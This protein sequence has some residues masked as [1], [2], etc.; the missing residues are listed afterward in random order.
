MIV[1]CHTHIFESGRG[2]PF[3][4]PGGA[5]D[6]V[7]EMDAHLVDASIVLPTP[8]SATNEFVQ[9][10]CSR[11]PGRLI[12]F[13]NP[14]FKKPKK[15]VRLMESFFK[16]HGFKGL[17][18]HPRLQGVTVEDSVVGEVLA[19]AQEHNVVVLFDVFMWGPT[20]DNL[21]LHPM[22]YHRVAQTFP[23]LNMILAHAG[24]Y[25]LHEAFMVAKSNSNVYLDISFTPVYFQGSSLAA[26]C[27]L[28][29]TRLPAG[30]VMFGSDFPFVKYKDSLT[31]VDQL[32][33]GCG[34]AISS[35]VMGNAVATLLNLKSGS[36]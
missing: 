8:G 1:D 10:E 13:Y 23:R 9:R 15:T 12:A 6:L 33:A 24:G 3:D 32:L 25:K 35:E 28:L 30:R 2:G 20:L 17:K 11:Y 16:T 21:A 27:A 18:I 31:A 34:T 26:D 22:A 14:D 19:W 4:L 5:D 7:R 29:C 36:L